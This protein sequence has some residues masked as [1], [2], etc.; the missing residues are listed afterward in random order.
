MTEEQMFQK[1][2]RDDDCALNALFALYSRHGQADIREARTA[3]GEPW[4][5]AL[6]DEETLIAYAQAAVKSRQEGRQPLLSPYHLDQVRQRLRGYGEQLLTIAAE[7]QRRREA[8]AERIDLSESDPLPPSAGWKSALL[9]EGDQCRWRY[10][11][12]MAPL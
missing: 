1:I 3:V 11:D 8:R 10:P 4:G 5:F 6:P 2:D 9:I 12:E 7:K